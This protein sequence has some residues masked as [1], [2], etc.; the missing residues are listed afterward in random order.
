MEQQQFSNDIGFENLLITLPLQE[1][2]SLCTTNS[3]FY[4][5]CQNEYIW[6]LRLI[7]DFPHHN[8]LIKP[9][10]IT[11]RQFYL[12]L[13]STHNF[14]RIYLDNNVKY[15]Y[16]PR[17][18]SG[19]NQYLERLK[20]IIVNNFVLPDNYL[21]LY[22]NNNDAY[23]YNLHPLAYSTPLV[24]TYLG[25]WNIDE[26]ILSPPITQIYIYTNP[27]SIPPTDFGGPI[28]TQLNME[29]T[30]LNELFIN[31]IACIT[32]VTIDVNGNQIITI[33]WND[34]QYTINEFHSLR[35]WY[36]DIYRLLESLLPQ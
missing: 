21:I 36:T 19:F 30:F 25:D 14:V 1:L 18:V 13:V 34:R 32:L 24:S 29:P 33:K 16:L 2:L 4:Q 23:D 26:T 35:L 10:D 15:Y 7:R 3:N 6:R 11:W 28:L 20:E 5:A 8:T 17:L 31:W 9:D 22:N 12:N 27:N